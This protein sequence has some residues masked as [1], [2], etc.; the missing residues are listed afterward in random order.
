MNKSKKIRIVYKIIVVI[1]I[2][3]GAYGLLPSTL[4]DLMKDKVEEGYDYSIVY[5]AIVDNEYDIDRVKISD[6]KGIDY[7][8]ENLKSTDVSFKKI[9][10]HP[11]LKAG[12]VWYEITDMQHIKSIQITDSGEVYTMAFHIPQLS[13]VYSISEEELQVLFERIEQIREIYGEE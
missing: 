9:I 5:K 11:E 8:W 13:V 7:L 10:R 12:E 6:P 1:I 2:A 3:I 4:A